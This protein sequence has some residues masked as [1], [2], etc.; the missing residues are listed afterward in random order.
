MMT[1]REEILAKQRQLNVLFSAW[2]AEKKQ[3]EIV[4]FRRENG[5]LVEHYPNGTERVISHAE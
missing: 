1:K 2:M 5:D 3:H 4:T